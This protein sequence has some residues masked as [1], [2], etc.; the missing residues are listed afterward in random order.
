MSMIQLIGIGAATFILILLIIALIVTRRRER[1][2]ATAAAAP[3]RPVATPRPGSAPPAGSVLDG[4][5]R[6]DLY[7][8]R[9]EKPDEPGAP[10][11][12]PAIIPSAVSAPSAVEP[13]GATAPAHETGTPDEAEERAH[14][15]AQSAPGD[16]APSA[17]LWAGGGAAA[18][19]ADA[20]DRDLWGRR[21]V[22]GSD[23]AAAATD[24]QTPAVE[25]AVDADALVTEPAAWEDEE[26][27]ELEPVIHE[28]QA[29]TDDPWSSSPTPDEPSVDDR[30]RE[31]PEAGGDAGA[32]RRPD[33]TADAWPPGLYEPTPIDAEQIPAAGEAE[34]VIVVGAEEA[35]ADATGSPRSAFASQP[36]AADAPAAPPAW[37]DEAVRDD[38]V[39]WTPATGVSTG[40]SA[41]RTRDE[42]LEPAGPSATA[43]AQA[44]SVGEQWREP[45]ATA[46]AA[47]EG[48]APAEG[49]DRPAE[50]S[51][52]TATAAGA[53]GRERER[54]EPR[55]VRLCD[56]IST[57]NSQHVDLNDP[58]VRRM[59]R[60]L[61]QS[62]VDLAQQYKQLGQN[63]DA[64]LQLTEAQKICRA[65]SMDS[66]A[67]LLDQM[68]RELQV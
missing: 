54:R 46:P 35:E 67:K 39:I 24:E 65:L 60:E 10:E 30:V 7:R 63:I 8:L 45:A 49:P 28:K 18:A 38:T 42:V 27:A 4:A 26:G 3:P 51:G 31:A 21:A 47:D 61:V 5:P 9:G 41:S 14:E 40:P 43:A 33:T 50:V 25:P 15:P 53:A 32:D 23:A 66:H 12:H 16:T 44:Q 64:V 29:L 2:R 56:I 19:D 11:E 34:D 36:A 1:A 48:P 6:D 37:H 55:L 13:F 62:E 59:L 52:A 58:D 22:S 17:A 20:A 68:I 57:T